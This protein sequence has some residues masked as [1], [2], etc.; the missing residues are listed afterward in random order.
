MKKFSKILITL[1]ALTI[2]STSFVA[3]SAKDNSSTS[4]TQPATGETLKENTT[5]EDIVNKITEDIGIQ[6]P[7]PV[8]EVLLN[9]MYYISSDLVDDYFGVAAMVMTSSDHV[10]A[11]KAAPGKLEDV[12]AGL[13]KRKEDV[14]ANFAQYLP[15][16]YEKAQAGKVI[17]KGDYAFLIIIG[18]Y[19]KG[20]DNEMAKAEEIINSFF[21]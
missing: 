6:M 11:I 2:V 13:E 19:D 10:V 17:V 4:T 8:D 18:D 1:L 7:G 15:D 14:I 16:Q 3:C 21:N 9:D 5:L 20:F 12:V